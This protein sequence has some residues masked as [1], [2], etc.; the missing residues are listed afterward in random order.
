M[1]DHRSN[2]PESS[3]WAAVGNLPRRIPDKGRVLLLLAEA[4]DRGMTDFELAHALGKQQ[5]S[6]GK[7]RGELVE[8]KKVEWS[9]QHRAAPSGARARVWRIVR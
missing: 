6:I 3:R 9:G 4:G 8:A 1:H 5:T 2:D 7:R